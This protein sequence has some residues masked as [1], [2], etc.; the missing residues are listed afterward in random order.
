MDKELRVLLS[1]NEIGSVHQNRHGHLSFTYDDEWRSRIDSTP[2]SLSMPLTQKEHGR[3]ATENYLWGL[4]SDDPQTR[5]ELAK[6]KGVSPRN[7]FALLSAYGEDS[8]GA[9]QIVAPD[10]I[11][12]LEG[13]K[14]M[15]RISERRLAEF[16][17]NLVKHPG[18][19]QIKKSGGKFSLP[20]AQPKK[21]ICWTGGN[22]FEPKGRTPSTHIL[23]PPSGMLDGQ[24]ENEYFC[25]QLAAAIGLRT[26]DAR[27]VKIGGLPNI[28]VERYDRYRLLRGKLAPLTQAGGT[29]HRL[30]QEDVCQALSYHPDDKYQRDGG[31]SMKQVMGLL[32]GSGDAVVDRERFMRACMFNYVIL[33]ID[34]HAKNYSLLIEHGGR[35]RL[36]PL[37]DVISAIPYDHEEYSLLAMKVGGEGKWR[38]IGL[39]HWEK[40]AKNCG[41]SVSA[42]ADYLAFLADEVPKKATQLMAQAKADGL[43]TEGAISKIVDG[44]HKRCGNLKRTLSAA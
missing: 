22:W 36:A 26:C 20:G 29:V 40:E 14:G 34:A 7:A 38:N 19:T 30:H 10:R 5:E 16:L 6:R 37:Y 9:V 23:K 32:N 44:L 17:A 1:D 31:P 25:I 15:T 8:V 12:E 39:Y 27:V 11:P 24:V 41:Y 3:K 42:T 4:I 21:A 18:Q 35:F 33:G 13:R 28:V 2:L 43:N